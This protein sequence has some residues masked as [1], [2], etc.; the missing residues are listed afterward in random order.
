MCGHH[1]PSHELKP[2]KWNISSKPLLPADGGVDTLSAASMLGGVVHQVAKD[3]PEP[4]GVGFHSGKFL[5]GILVEE[6]LE[7]SRIEDGRFTLSMEQ[8]DLKA[9][10]EDAVYTYKEFFR[11]DGLELRYEDTEEE[12]PAVEPLMAVRGVRSS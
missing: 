2:R 9:E 4:L 8:V 5:F 3:L 10:F 12:F 6:L 7:F 1:P 11:K